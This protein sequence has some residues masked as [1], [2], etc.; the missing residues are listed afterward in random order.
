MICCCLQLEW[1]AEHV[2]SHAGPAIV[3]LSLGVPLG[4][5]SA[6]LEGAIRTIVSEYNITVIVA[7]GN[8]R[9]D[10]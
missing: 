2:E 6:P 9:T 1:V 10:R 8:S 3:T 5:W 4:S 7:S